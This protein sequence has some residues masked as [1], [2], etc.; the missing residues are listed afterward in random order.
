MSK[1]LKLNQKQ[2]WSTGVTYPWLHTCQAMDWFENTI[3]LPHL[4]WTFHPTIQFSASKWN[5]VFV[6]RKKRKFTYQYESIPEYQPPSRPGQGPGWGQSWKNLFF[7]NTSDSLE[8]PL[9]LIQY[10]Y[11]GWWLQFWCRRRLVAWWTRWA[12]LPNLPRNH[13][14]G[15]EFFFFFFFN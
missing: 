6:H 13:A 4:A 10:I 3:N 8:K 9:A 11:G 1:L 14:K 15:L 12:M 2:P 5:C 7:S